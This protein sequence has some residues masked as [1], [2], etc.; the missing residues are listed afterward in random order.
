MQFHE[1]AISGA[2]VVELDRL[3]DDR[4]FFARA[5]CADEFAATGI[6]PNVVQ[7]NLS[8]NVSK[9]T[10]RGMHY[11]VSPGLETKFVRC[12]RGCIYDVIV[13]LR[14][15][16]DTYL[17]HFG[18]ELSSDTRSALYIPQKVAHGFQ[19][20]SDESEVMYLVSGKYNP[21][22]ERGVRYDDPKFDIQ[23]PVAVTTVSEK[24][25][26]WSLFVS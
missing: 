10:L 18:V 15:D 25:A 3:E 11:Q 5:F 16:S 2:Y 19:T 8:F 22:C 7:A 23:W 20:L 13:D 4:G 26:N 1:T 12:I 17:K 14:P 9:G 6:N 24:D 21:A